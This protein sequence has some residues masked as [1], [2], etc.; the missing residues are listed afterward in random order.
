MKSNLYI[1]YNFLDEWVT[2]YDIN[3][4]PEI[5]C[6]H[7]NAIVFTREEVEK[8]LDKLRS[9]GYT[10]LESAR[11]V[12]KLEKYFSDGLPSSEE[13]F[14]CHRVLTKHNISRSEDGEI[15]LDAVGNPWCKECAREF[16]SIKW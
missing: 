7:N 15:R 16:D 12:D 14:V 13:C 10:G 5:S 4:N 2:G 6:I 8:E 9:M 1:I 3:G 11:I